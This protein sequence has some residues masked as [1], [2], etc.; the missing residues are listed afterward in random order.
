MSGEQEGVGEA[1]MADKVLHSVKYDSI[2]ITF[3]AGLTEQILKDAIFDMVAPANPLRLTI[4]SS[5]SLRTALTSDF[6]NIL[7]F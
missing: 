2:H 1:A 7:F 3:T 4:H 5:L 6:I